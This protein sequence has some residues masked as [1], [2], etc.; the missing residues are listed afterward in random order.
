M[1]YTSFALPNHKLGRKFSAIPPPHSPLLRHSPRVS[2]GYATAER[3]SVCRDG[4]PTAYEVLGIQNSATSQEIKSAYRKLARVLHPDVAPKY[5]DDGASSADEFMRVHAAY[6][7]LS[8][9]D[10]RAVY[11]SSLFRR[12]RSAATF[13][14]GGYS[15]VTRRR[16]TWETDQCWWVS[17]R[18]QTPVAQLVALITQAPQ[19]HRTQKAGLGNTTTKVSTKLITKCSGERVSI[20]QQRRMIAVAEKTIEAQIRGVGREL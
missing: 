16:R 20:H 9:P 13:S 15:E 5:G 8:D 11:D 6:A 4:K 12:R 19:R 14:A 17:P 18:P 10:K 2:A 3:I 7:T 1:A